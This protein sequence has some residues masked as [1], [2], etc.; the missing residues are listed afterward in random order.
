[1]SKCKKCENVLGISAKEL[2]DLNSHAN[3]IKLWL[4]WETIDV[5][6]KGVSGK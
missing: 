3:D 5:K 2:R 4:R 1:M 6:L